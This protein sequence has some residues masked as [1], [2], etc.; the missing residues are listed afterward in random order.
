[1]YESE[2]TLAE[3]QGE[4]RQLLTGKKHDDSEE[5]KSPN[6]MRTNLTS[7]TSEEEA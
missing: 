5:R 3:G 7:E 6:P 1:L 4:N 2:P